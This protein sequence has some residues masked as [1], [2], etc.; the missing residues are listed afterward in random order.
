MAISQVKVGSTTH[1]IN[2]VSAK[3]FTTAAG[4]TLTGDITGTA[5]SI[6]GWSLSTSLAD[7]AVKTSKI[8]DS[9][10]TSAKIADSA[11]GTAKIA[12]SAVTSAK[13]ANNAITNAKLA[14]NSVGTAEIV[15]GSV[16]TQKF[17][18]E[19]GIVVVQ[20]AEPA[21]NGAAKIWIKI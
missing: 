11:I 3:A 19:V 13:I 7:G 6:H 20:S 16:T 10:V 18:D 9:A 2:A 12:K 1:D 17:A 15:D 14:D 8:A 21:A 4:V 5:S